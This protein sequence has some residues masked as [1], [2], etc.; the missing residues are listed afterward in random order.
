MRVSWGD[1]VPLFPDPSTNLVPGEVAP[2]PFPTPISALRCPP[3]KP[4]A[5]DILPKFAKISAT[6]VGHS[7][8][9]MNLSGWEQ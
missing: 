3:I 4:N 8:E 1:V 2:R 5:C 7:L 6:Y 9:L